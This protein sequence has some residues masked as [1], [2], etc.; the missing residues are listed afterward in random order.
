MREVRVFSNG[1]NVAI[2]KN[3]TQSSDLDDTKV[4]SEAVDDKWRTYSSTGDDC[5]TWW[6]VDLGESLPI[7]KVIIVNRK[8]VDDPECACKN[9]FAIVSL[10]DANGKWV[11]AKVHGDSC[12]KGWLVRHFPKVCW[13]QVGQ[14]IDGKA[15]DDWH[16]YST[17]ISADG[18][19]F[20]TGGYGN[21]DNGYGAG[22][23]RVFK[24]NGLAWE[25]KGQDILGSAAY[26]W[27][28][29]IVAISSDGNIIAVGESGH[30][31]AGSN[32][33]AVFVYQWNSTNSAWDQMGPT[34]LGKAAHDWTGTGPQSIDIS[35]DGM[36]VAVG[37]SNAD[38]KGNS[39]AGH[40][41]VYRFNNSGS[42]P[43]WEQVGQEIQ[44]TAAD[45]WLG[46]TVS[47]S[48]DG[49]TVAVS[50]DFWDTAGYVQVYKLSVDGTTWEQMG[51]DIQAK[52]GGDQF[53]VS[54]SLSG[55][56]KTVVVGGPYSDVNGVDSGYV[57]VYNWN[58]ADTVWEQ[59]G[60]D[61]I[62]EAEG[63][64]FGYS[65]SIS[66]DGMTFAAGAFGNDGN[67][68]DSGHVR[69]F[70]WNS[71]KEIWEQVGPDIDGEAEG[72]E[73]GLTTAISADGSIV[74]IGGQN[75]DGNGYRAG[76]V[77]VF[78]LGN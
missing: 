26:G 50:A 28:G 40:V 24:W 42:S 63:D 19:T 73:S 41:T 61:I 31:E 65:L 1:V 9:S 74:A 57:Q 46:W 55:N 53:G 38:P 68:P 71:S 21:D 27:L 34:I 77:R 67:G 43:V 72:D 30:S 59:V 70:K 49:Q 14:D 3:A 66:S 20:V 48:H 35:S 52:A 76:H 47:L 4:A 44:G 15:A 64:R 37:A 60:Q 33:G 12:D 29:E 6:Q 11:D 69:V 7:D 45:D 78:E 54:F 10:L 17:A 16:G 18:L 62:A 75:N 51:Q 8:C 25:Q 32:A 13:N 56:G 36:T 22:N 2:G 5:S 58:S 39:N 23:A